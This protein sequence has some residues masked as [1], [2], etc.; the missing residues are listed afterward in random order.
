MAKYL[1]DECCLEDKGKYS[2]DFEHSIQVVGK[3]ARDREVF[4]Y[5]VQNNLTLITKDKH[6]ALKSALHIP[7][8]CRDGFE[9]YEI[10]LIPRPE[11]NGITTYYLHTNDDIIRP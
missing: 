6:F 2:S 4:I 3:A 5:A 1:L 9:A 7:V 10:H 8:I 11:L